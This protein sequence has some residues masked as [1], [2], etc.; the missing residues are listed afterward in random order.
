MRKLILA[1]LVLSLIL[2]SCNEALSTDSINTDN[3][4]IEPIVYIH[5]SVLPHLLSPSTKSATVQDLRSYEH[6]QF[7]SHLA[8]D[9][10]LE[11]GID[12]SPEEI[13]DFVRTEQIN[14]FD[15][16]DAESKMTAL[17]YIER[18]PYEESVKS[19]LKQLYIKDL[20]E[21]SSLLEDYLFQ[22]ANT[23]TKSQ[24]GCSQ[25]SF[26]SLYNFYRSD[27][28]IWDNYF[29]TKGDDKARHVVAVATDVFVGAVFSGLTGF[30][31]AVAAGAIGALASEVMENG[32]IDPDSTT[33]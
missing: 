10:A 33:D 19:E 25:F 17:S 28:E 22:L 12:V 21:G 27:S 14:F 26:N 18:L 5:N 4:T 32:E 1:S 7:V 23:S 13:I 30:W 29:A 20:M 9:A 6:A 31:G 24:E 8:C 11:I 3:L 16:F 15:I 2:S